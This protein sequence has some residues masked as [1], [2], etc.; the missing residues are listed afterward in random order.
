MFGFGGF[1]GTT[2]FG[3]AGGFGGGGG[4]GTTTAFGGGGGLTFG[5]PGPAP[6]STFGTNTGFSWQVPATSDN[7]QN[8][9]QDTNNQNDEVPVHEEKPKDEWSEKSWTI[10]GMDRVKS[11]K[12]DWN[13][14]YSSCL[15]IIHIFNDSMIRLLGSIEV[16]QC[17]ST[18]I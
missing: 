18:Y 10:P 2:T 8:T 5:A 7:N 16:S 15:S 6:N 14:Q 13:R 4:F 11:D 9:N 17:G 1:G 3:G 12:I